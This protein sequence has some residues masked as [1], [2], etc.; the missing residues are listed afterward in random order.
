MPVVLPTPKDLI[1]IDGKSQTEKS[2][3][4]DKIC[5][6]CFNRPTL[7]EFRI[8]VNVTKFSDPLFAK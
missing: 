8:I 6:G 5:I 3:Y 4:I 2:N 1:E 7:D